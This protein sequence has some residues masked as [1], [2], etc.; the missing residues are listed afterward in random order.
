VGQAGQWVAG[1]SDRACYAHDVAIIPHPE[2][3]RIGPVLG[4]PVRPPNGL[5][6]SRPVSRRLVC[7]NGAGPAGRVGS[8]ELLSG[9][10]SLLSVKKSNSVAVL[11]GHAAHSRLSGCDK[12]V[13]FVA[14]SW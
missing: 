8:M 2:R 12:K 9:A 6:M 14:A 5:E 3:E 7:T 10:Q 13:G 4:V 11:A 1:A